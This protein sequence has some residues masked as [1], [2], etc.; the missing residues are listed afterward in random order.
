MSLI[1]KF[2][3]NRNKKYGQAFSTKE[4]EYVLAELYSFCGVDKPSYSPGTSAEETAYNEGKRRVA[5]HIKGILGQSDK[6]V[7]QLV[8]VYQD[9]RRQSQIDFANNYNRG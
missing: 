1:K 6:D 2:F 7:E 4:G 8:K 5:L 3:G 9:S